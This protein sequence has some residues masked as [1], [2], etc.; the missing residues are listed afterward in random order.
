MT[1]V[2]QVLRSKGSSVVTIGPTATI[3]EALTLMSEKNIGA[4]VVVQDEKIAGIF[5]E[6]DYA[7]KVILEG[8]S[9]KETLVSDLMTPKV[10]CVKASRTMEECM[11][12][13]SDKH[14]RHLPVVENNKLSG[15]VTMR[16]VIKA[17]VA[18]KE[19]TIRDLENYIQGGYTG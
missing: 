8:R 17:V 7:R 18:N 1:T 12:L 15:I 11:M 4:L 6:R 2:S 5:S 10:F 13:M 3:Y 19:N 9:S 16:D 14:I